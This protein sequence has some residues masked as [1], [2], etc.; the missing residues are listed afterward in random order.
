MTTN[1]APIIS[2]SP[3]GVL[4]NGAKDDSDAYTDD[5]NHVSE[6]ET[7]SAILSKSETRWVTGAK[8]LVLFV[9]FLAAFAASTVVYFSTK[10]SE[11]ADFKVRVSDVVHGLGSEITSH[12]LM[13]QSFDAAFSL[14]IL[15]IKSLQ[16]HR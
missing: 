7:E 10:E 11:D 12:R 16:C 8:A 6:A 5:G 4:E 14:T 9:I 3:E 2:D 1:N 15:R 13:S